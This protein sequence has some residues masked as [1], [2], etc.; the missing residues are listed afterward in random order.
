M[1][2]FCRGEIGGWSNDGVE[3]NETQSNETRVTCL[4]NHLTS[5]AVLVSIRDRDKEQVRT[6]L[7]LLHHNYII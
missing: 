6:L 1:K 7:I 4:A 3:L 5:F 2:T